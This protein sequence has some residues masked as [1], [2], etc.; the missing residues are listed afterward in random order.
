MA[1]ALL[2]PYRQAMIRRLFFLLAVPACASA[3]VALTP[4]GAQ[5]QS[6]V[7]ISVAAT[8]TLAHSRVVATVPVQ[9]TCA[10]VGTVFDIMPTATIE[11][12]AGHAIAS[13]S[14]GPSQPIVCDGT[15][16]P[17]TVTFLA[18]PAGP[19]FHGGP[20][21]VEVSVFIFGSG[22]SE[23]GSSGLQTVTLKG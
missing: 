2:S 19:P 21:A 6:A 23:S 11:Q 7:T 20:A 12:A 1:R 5:A 3:V 14:G 16:H 13:G 8:G 15:P 22:G 17:N 18:D 4:L 10:P 9:I